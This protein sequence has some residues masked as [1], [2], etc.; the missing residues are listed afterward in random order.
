LPIKLCALLI[1]EQNNWVVS[2]ETYVLTEFMFG[3]NWEKMSGTLQKYQKLTHE[4]P[5]W[6]VTSRWKERRSR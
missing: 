4:D 6:F 1:T 3:L 5:S 2:P